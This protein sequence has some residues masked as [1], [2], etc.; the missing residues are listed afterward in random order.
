[1]NFNPI[2]SEKAD[3]TESANAL[4]LPIAESVGN[5][6]SAIWTL[7]FGRFDPIAE[8][9]KLK[10]AHDLE[11]FKNSLNQK[12]SVIPVEDLCEPK[13]SIVGPALEASKYYF[14]ENSLRD[15]F[16]TLIANSMNLAFQ[17]YIQNSFVEVIKQMSPLDAL[18]LKEFVSP[19]GTYND[20]PVLR[21]ATI[22]NSQLAGN[23]EV[24]CSD[25]LAEYQV[26]KS[27]YY[28]SPE[29]TIFTEENISVLFDDLLRLGLITVPEN[30]LIADFN[31]YSKYES[32]PY[33]NGLLSE[34]EYS[35][36]YSVRFIYMAASLTDYGEY[37]CKVCL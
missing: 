10:W 35:D 24:F 36:E 34:Y 4:L 20:L 22:E 31:R 12:V 21:I 7:T 13:L 33:I 5:T 19:T 28:S 26:K 30:S 3:F 14:E 6:L 27:Y 11:E 18:L 32:D 17:D 23:D 29:K 1:M 8:K 15:M 2:S 16:A 25:L 9:Y 37:F